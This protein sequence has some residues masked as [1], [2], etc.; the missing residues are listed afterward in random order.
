M[1]LVPG[2]HTRTPAPRIHGQR[3][4]AT[5][6][7][8]RQPGEGE[9]LIP[10]APGNLRPPPRRATLRMARK[11]KGHPGSPHLHTRARSMSAVDPSCLPK[12]RAPQG[13]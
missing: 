7:K 4:P 13:G 3:A 9:D 11:P 10:D 6:P 1:G 8:D 12:G 5:Y 2:P